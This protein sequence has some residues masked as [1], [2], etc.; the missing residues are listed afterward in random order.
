MIDPAF[1]LRSITQSPFEAAKA[2]PAAPNS[3]S[4]AAVAAAAAPTK[5][6]AAAA[7]PVQVQASAGALLAADYLGADLGGFGSEDGSD[8]FLS[9]DALD[10]LADR[11]APSASMAV[12]ADWRKRRDLTQS[13]LIQKTIT[14]DATAAVD[15]WVNDQHHLMEMRLRWRKVSV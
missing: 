11:I 3:P 12:L 8:A 9:D 4:A 14:E 13:V 1:A 5:S 15:E 7:V 2:A 6:A 10:E